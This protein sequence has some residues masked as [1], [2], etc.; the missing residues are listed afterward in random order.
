MNALVRARGC[1]H[2]EAGASLTLALVFITALGFIG[3]TTLSVANSTLRDDHANRTIRDD[4]YGAGGAIDVYINAMRATPTWGRDGSPCAALT[5]TFVAGRTITVTCTPVT[6]SGALIVGGAGARS[7]RVVDLAATIGGRRLAAA[8]AEFVD[9]GG[10]TPGASV[11]IRN[12]ITA[13]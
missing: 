8:R 10:S 4:V 7:N 11:R 6:N 12:W 1:R 2:G 9:G 13:S 5:T 3:L